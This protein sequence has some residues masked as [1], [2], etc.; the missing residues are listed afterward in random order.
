MWGNVEADRRTGYYVAGHDWPAISND[1]SISDIYAALEGISDEA[2]ESA[3][4]TL[5]NA[6]EPM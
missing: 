3:R 2:V 1:F 4:R 6:D 5:P